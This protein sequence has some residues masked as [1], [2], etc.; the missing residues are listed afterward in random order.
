MQRA[1]WTPP[2]TLR[3]IHCDESIAV[4]QVAD[5]CVVI[6]RGAVTKGPFEWQRAGLAEVVERRPRGAGFLCVV[7]STA[8]PP[9]DEL[10]RASS[11][12]VASHGK[13]LSCVAC[14]IEGVGFRAAINRSAL[15]GMVL[16]LRNKQAP[17]SVFAKVTDAAEWMAQ[18][19]HVSPHDFASTVEDIRSRLP[20]P[21]R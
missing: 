21:A 5:M 15:A 11:D 6:W 17:V 14:V 9:N 3:I 13:R 7:E 2:G 10:R 4:A 8:K 18:F 20:A 12:M 1:S 16:L 19:I